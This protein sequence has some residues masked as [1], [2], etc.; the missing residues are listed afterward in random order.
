VAGAAH[1]T[2]QAGPPSKSSAARQHASPGLA[3]FTRGRGRST[4]EPLFFAIRHRALSLPPLSPTLPVPVSES[5]W[6]TLAASQACR[7]KLSTPVASRLLTIS[8]RP[9]FSPSD[10]APDHVPPQIRVISF[11]VRKILFNLVRQHW[12]NRH[13]GGVWTTHKLLSQVSR[14]LRRTR[15]QQTCLQRGE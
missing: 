1:G 9:L 4:G 3:R 10:H 13:W 2:G 6:A 8:S 14:C 11:P 15:V 12:K 7:L 5:H